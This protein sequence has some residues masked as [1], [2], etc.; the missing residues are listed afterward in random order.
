MKLEGISSILALA[1]WSSWNIWLRGHP[2]NLTA[3][4][5]LK[6]R[7]A[8]KRKENNL[9]TIIFQ[10]LYWILGWILGRTFWMQW[11]H[12]FAPLICWFYQKAS[13][14]ATPAK[15]NSYPPVWIH[16]NHQQIDFF[17]IELEFLSSEWLKMTEVKLAISD[18]WPMSHQAPAKTS[19]H[20][21]RFDVQKRQQRN[22]L[23][24]SPYCF[25][26]AMMKRMLFNQQSKRWPILRSSKFILSQT[27][28]EKS[29][30]AK[31]SMISMILEIL[32]LPVMSGS[33]L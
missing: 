3:S 25:C 22:L 20:C 21:C 10:G 24:L 30:L 32:E 13:Q 19:V 1:C 17:K 12:H 26:G 27:A 6:I 23:A 15:I 2:G 4:L 5:H 16:E 9:P 33:F 8:L 7:R 18:D 11:F 29:V 14:K 28:G 31:I